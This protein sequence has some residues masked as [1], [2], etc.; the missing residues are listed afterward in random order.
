[1]TVRTI[2][3]VCAIRTRRTIYTIL[4]I[5]SV[6]YFHLSALGKLNDITNLDS[7]I[8]DWSYALDI[9]IILKSIHSDRKCFDI[10]ICR[11]NLR[12]E[13]IKCLL[14]REGE[15]TTICKFYDHIVYI[16]CIH[17]L[18]QRISPLS[19]LTSLTLVSLLTFIS[20]HALIPLITSSLADIIPILSTING[21]I[22]IAVLDLQLWSDRICTSF[23]LW[24]LRSCLALRTLRT[25]RTDR[26]LLTLWALRTCCTSCSVLAVLAIGAIKTDSLDSVSSSI[27]KPFTIKS[28]VINTISR[29]LTYANLRSIA[30]LSVCTVLSISTVIDNYFTTLFKGNLITYL[31]TFFHDWNHASNIILFLKSK[32]HCL[33]RFYITIGLL[34]KGIKTGLHLV[35]L[36]V[37]LR[38]FISVHI[39]A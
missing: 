23:T 14:C 20:L 6:I 8:I 26:S 2:D 4:T 31:N 16:I 25:L 32:N 15:L 29:I 7:A 12:C 11:I 38:D 1:M 18:E 13:I 36:L 17:A 39:L 37:K 5:L 19:F 28:P 35:N 21:D 30:I 24:T 10:G 22:P 3:S 9:I 27:S 34:T 33:E